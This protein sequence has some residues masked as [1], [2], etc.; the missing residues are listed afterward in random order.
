L[1]IVGAVTVTA[2]TLLFVT[3]VFVPLTLLLVFVTRA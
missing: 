3:A 1:T 2:A